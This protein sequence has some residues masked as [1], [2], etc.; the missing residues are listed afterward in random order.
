MLLLLLMLLLNLVWTLVECIQHQSK[1]ISLELFEHLLLLLHELLVLIEGVLMG[2]DQLGITLVVSCR[3]C[4][5][6]FISLID[7]GSNSYF[8]VIPA[9]VGVGAHWWSLI[10]SLL[11]LL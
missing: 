4:D 6:L 7:G 8:L 10:S 1:F 11:K 2:I 5:N 9:S 3:N